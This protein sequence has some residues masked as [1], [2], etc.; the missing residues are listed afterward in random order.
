MTTHSLPDPA[1]V[2]KALKSSGLFDALRSSLLDDH[3][4]S[5]MGAATLSNV[6]T[7]LENHRHYIQTNPIFSASI[8][9]NAV[10]LASN[11]SSI[12]TL[13]EGGVASEVQK[14]RQVLDQAVKRCA[15]I[16]FGVV[17]VQIIFSYHRISP[18]SMHK[19]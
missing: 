17:L 13:F 7:V 15:H 6:Q 18:S 16:G 14:V 10:A 9:R 3:K 2:V 11:P 4:H 5:Q 19:S 8:A 12:S 1:D